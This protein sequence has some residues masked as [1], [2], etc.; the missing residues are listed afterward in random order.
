MRLI[1]KSFLVLFLSL[2]LLVGLAVL[3]LPLWGPV[4]FERG[5]AVVLRGAGFSESDVTLE[6]LGLSK[7]SLGLERLRYQGV[8]LSDADLSVRYTV[9][10]LRSAKLEQVSLYQPQVAVDLTYDW[11]TDEDSVKEDKPSILDQLPERFPLKKVNIDGAQFRLKGTDW[12]RQLELDF[13]LSGQERLNGQVTLGTEGLR[14]D[15]Q[16]ELLWS[17][18]SGR[19]DVSAKVEKLADWITFAR[20][21][22]WLNLPE[23]LGLDAKPLEIEGGFAFAG[24]SLRGWNL[25]LTNNG[26]SSSLEPSGFSVESVELETKGEGAELTHLDLKIENGMADHKDLDLSF[27]QLLALASSAEQIGFRLL[28]WELSGEGQAGGLGSVSASAGDLELF[29]EGPWQPWHEDFLTANLGLSLRVEK[30]ALSLFTGLGSASGNW[31]VDAKVSSNEARALSLSSELLEA[32]LAAS[33]VSLES[34]RLTLSVEGTFPD[35]LKAVVGVS[36][37]RISWSDGE[38]S[39][40]GLKGEIKLASL[41]PL[42]SK[43][44]QALQF[45]SIEQGDFRAGSGSLLLDYA[46]DRKEGSPMKLEMKTDALGGKV[47]IVVN[48]QLTDPLSFSVRA[49]LTSVKLTEVAALF[50]QFDGCIEG[51]ASGELALRLKGNKIILQPGGL[52]LDEDTTGRVEYLRQGWLTQD[53]DLNP[54]RFVSERNI[55]DIMKDPQGATALTELAM[56]DLKMSEFSLKIEKSDGGKQGVVAQIKGSR[57]IKGVTVPVVL[58]LPIRGDVQETINTVFEFNSRR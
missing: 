51:V 18:R 29:V 36:D 50:P 12:A 14:T 37:G 53:P 21:R 31:Q 41:M 40:T 24:Q 7:L 9:K 8:A 5:S 56:R 44:Q 49:Y 33:G 15:S 25:G 52:Q 10:G 26:G 43:G 32:S 35:K 11:T 20:E 42:S 34:E 6:E 22:G 2:L 55:M 23:A 28:G 13:Q 30:A 48:G 54:E 19:V 38:G 3:T 46:L 4:A 27:E 57:I 17:E 58:N 16:F 47:R 39:L 1:L 45:A